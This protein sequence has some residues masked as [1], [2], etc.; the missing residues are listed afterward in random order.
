ML[1]RLVY[2]RGCTNE[3]DMGFGRVPLK[4]YDTTQAPRVFKPASFQPAKCVPEPMHL[5]I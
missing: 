5:L 1:S 2:N 3:E 4:R